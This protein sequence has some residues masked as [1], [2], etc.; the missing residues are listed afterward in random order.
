MSSEEI[1]ATSAAVIAFFTSLVS[2]W[3]GFLN[4]QYYRLSTKPHLTLERECVEG[5]PYKYTLSNNGLGPAIINNFEI[6]FD[7]YVLDGKVENI[8]KIIKLIELG[9]IYCEFLLPTK[10]E[11]IA[12]SKEIILLYIDP[13]HLN[14][15]AL[16]S[17][18]QLTNCLVFKV[19][20]SSIYGVTDC[21]EGCD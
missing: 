2:I 21:Y 4:R 6:I 1:I 9:D 15:Q 5:V 3:Q 17:L 18:K 19:E 11:A 20:Y 12:T 7:G 16:D 13:E 8:K 10:G 14:M